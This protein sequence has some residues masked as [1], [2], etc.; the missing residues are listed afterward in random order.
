[1]NKDE[2]ELTKGEETVMEFFWNTERPLTVMEISQM[3]NQFNEC[4]I[5]RLIK[6]LEKK[7]MLKDCGMQRSGKQYARQFIPTITR[8]E[9][10]VTLME[11]LGIQGKKSLAKFFAAM[12]RRPDSREIQSTDELI[13][14]LENIIEE[15]KEG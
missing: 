1:M 2:F 15:L 10:G 3:T 7:E 11:K 4:Y 8:E 6:S 12:V 9:Y 5:H 14:E 13:C